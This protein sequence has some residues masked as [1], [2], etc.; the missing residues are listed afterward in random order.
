MTGDGR[1]F[2]LGAVRAAHDGR[3]VVL[4][5]AQPRLLLTYLALQRGRIVPNDELGEVLWGARPA[6]H[7]EG[8]LRGVVTKVRVFLRELG[9][10]GP[11]LEHVGPGYRITGT[12][13]PAVDVGQA[14]L[15]L[16]HA[17]A[18]VARGDGGAAVAAAVEAVGLLVPPLLAGVDAD[19]LAPWR[20][21]FDGPA[22]WSRPGTCCSTSST[23]P[24]P[25]Q[26]RRWWR[27]L[28]TRPATVR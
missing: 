3:E 10:D 13:G 12:D 21:R 23:T 15:A 8:A 11:M 20:A 18:A 19:W 22:W 16:A 14:E 24:W 27:T 7:W 6:R 17:D 2:L 28:T 4:A 1:L 5:G 25:A 26:V 9:P